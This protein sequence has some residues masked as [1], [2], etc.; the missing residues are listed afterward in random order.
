MNL[1]N[2]NNI[3]IQNQIICD[4]NDKYTISTN[5]YTI[6]NSCCIE[7]LIKMKTDNKK[8]QIL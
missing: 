1:S 3:I 6:I 2:S 4:D 5:E 8:I 7:G